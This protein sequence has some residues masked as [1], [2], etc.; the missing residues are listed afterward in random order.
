[1]E[2]L[3][4]DYRVVHQ[5]GDSKEFKDFDRLTTLSARVSKKLQDRY[6][7]VKFVPP[8]DVGALMQE[9]DLVI[10][11]AGINTVTELL[12]FGKPS[13][14]IPLPSGQKKEQLTN[15]Q[16]LKKTGIGEYAQQE[17]LTPEVFLK[18]IHA[19]TDNLTKYKVHA[20]DAKSLVRSDAAA[21]IMKILYE[22]ANRKK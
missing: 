10:S 19:M 17:D 8:A 16:F 4:T 9:A 7:L 5:T 18:K 14:L 22:V 2:E 15:A 12:Q 6:T 11:R 20:H 13:F 1:L 3:L 21:R